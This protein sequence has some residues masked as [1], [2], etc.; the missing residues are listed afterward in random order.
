MG[1]NDGMRCSYVYL[2]LGQKSGDRSNELL[3]GSLM[4]LGGLFAFNSGGRTIKPAPFLKISPLSRR[5][6]TNHRHQMMIIG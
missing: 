6:A 4:N 5:P 3:V 2:L 1:S